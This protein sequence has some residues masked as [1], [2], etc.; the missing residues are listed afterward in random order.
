MR[1]WGLVAATR[2]RTEPP[3]WVV[4]GR[5]PSAAARAARELRERS[6]AGHFAV[7]FDVGRPL[8]LPAGTR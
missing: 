3:T 5:D 2:A 4:T 1:D 6:L 7:A 8:S